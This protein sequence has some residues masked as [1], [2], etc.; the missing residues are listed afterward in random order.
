MSIEI[1]AVTAVDV[2]GVGPALRAKLAAV[3]A[4]VTNTSGGASE[5]SGAV[6]GWYFVSKC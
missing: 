4:V 5:P 6:W 2:G 3:S 1:A